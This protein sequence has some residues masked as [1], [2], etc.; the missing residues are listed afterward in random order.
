M[1][2]FAVV[3]VADPEA[4]Q[5]GAD[6]LRELKMLQDEL[7]AELK[8]AT[9]PLN[10][11]LKTVRGWFAPLRQQL[12]TAERQQRRSLAEYKTEQDRLEAEARRKAEADARAERARLEAEA[13]AKEADAR[14]EAEERRQ[15]A[16][17][18]R[19]KGNEAAAARLEA[20]AYAI[21]VKAE[22]AADTLLA[23]AEAQVAEPVAA[24][25]P[26]AKGLADRVVWKFEVLD[27]SLLPREFTMPDESKIRKRV[28]ALHLDAVGL[29]G[30]PKAVKVWSETDFSARRK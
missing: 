8:K 12:E 13:R 9:A 21:E 17:L 30:G 15:A 3:T 24:A 25:A 23:R 27:A 20:K 16:E 2:K 14:R 11:A 5:R 1:S 28:A 22:A 6:N 29:L 26:K 4:F 18:E 19:Q 10:E 7:E